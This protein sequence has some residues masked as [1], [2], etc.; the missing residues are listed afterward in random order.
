MFWALQVEKYGSAAGYGLFDFLNDEQ[1]ALDYDEV[2]EFKAWWNG[3]DDY[4]RGRS[5]YLSVKEKEKLDEITDRLIDMAET[6][7][8]DYSSDEKELIKSLEGTRWYEEYCEGWTADDI[9][10]LTELDDTV[11][12]VNLVDW[13]AK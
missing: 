10:D 9:L 13:F 5:L 1:L 8:D 6:D 12:L 2:M 11:D 3:I 7:P 4:T